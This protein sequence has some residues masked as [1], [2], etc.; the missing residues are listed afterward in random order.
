[1]ESGAAWGAREA[2]EGERGEEWRGE[3]GGDEGWV[4][5]AEAL[6]K[7]DCLA[8]EASDLSDSLLDF[9]RTLNPTLRPGP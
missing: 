2:N 7:S 6:E 4:P 1:M 9:L 5:G 8:D 3:V